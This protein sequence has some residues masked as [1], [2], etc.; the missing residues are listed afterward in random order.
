VRTG[1]TGHEGK[2]LRVMRIISSFPNQKFVF[3]GDNSQQDPTIYAA[4]AAK[5][6]EKVEAVYIRNIV[7][8]NAEK[9]REIL[10]T[11]QSYGVKT[12]L[13]KNSAEAI[14][15]SRNIGLIAP[16]DEIEGIETII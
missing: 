14:T 13:F 4:I 16:L 1:K 2:L 8:Q 6:P 7:P 5:Y 9:T 3:F 11:I 12:Y 15:H 10:N